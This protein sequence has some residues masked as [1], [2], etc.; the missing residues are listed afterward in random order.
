MDG[1]YRMFYTDIRPH[2]Q[3]PQAILNSF[4]QSSLISGIVFCVIYVKAKTFKE[5]VIMMILNST[6]T[7]DA[8]NPSFW[9][10]QRHY[11]P[12]PSKTM[13]EIC[14]KCNHFVLYFNRYLRVL[15]CY[16]MSSYSGHREGEPANPRI[17]AICPIGEADFIGQIAYLFRNVGRF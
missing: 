1:P 6:Q 4:R 5:F 11:E 15:Y 14:P 10:C 16:N 3:V 8:A 9:S 7:Q 12:C 17:A 2:Q 13:V